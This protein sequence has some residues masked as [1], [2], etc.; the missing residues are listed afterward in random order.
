MCPHLKKLYSNVNL[1]HFQCGMPAYCSTKQPS[2]CYTL[3]EKLISCLAFFCFTGSL[4]SQSGNGVLS[5]AVPK[6]PQDALAFQEAEPQQRYVEIELDFLS[7][8][9]IEDFLKL[10]PRL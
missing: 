6:Y 3:W 1:Q 2:A 4:W 7:M 9:Q 8:G 5:S 10:D